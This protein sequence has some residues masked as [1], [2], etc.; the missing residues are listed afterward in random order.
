[1]ASPGG[2]VALSPE[3]APIVELFLDGT[4]KEERVE[5]K[6]DFEGGSV[7]A[8]VKEMESLL[9]QV[10]K[11]N[12]LQGAVIADIEGLPLASHLPAELD[13]DE[14]AATA[15]AIL[16]I[17]ETKLTDTDGSKVKQVSIDTEKEHLVISPVKDEYIVCVFAPKDVKLGIVLAAVRSIE[18]RL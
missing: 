9:A 2:E 17:T 11:D 12:G 8:T 3:K 4:E 5:E 16:S 14:I 13:E 18:K 7:M 1:M 10:V 6:K 15:A